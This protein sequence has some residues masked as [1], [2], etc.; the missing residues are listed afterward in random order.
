MNSIIEV[1][2]FEPETTFENNID[3]IKADNMK[4][5][6]PLDM[7]LPAVT[8]RKPHSSSEHL[9]ANLMTWILLQSPGK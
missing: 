3:E 8:S 2:K 6:T 4:S 1:A 7:N 9:N 5:I